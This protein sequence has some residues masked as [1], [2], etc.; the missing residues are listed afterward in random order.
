MVSAEHPDVTRPEQWTPE[1]AAHFLRSIMEWTT[2]Q[3][4]PAGGYFPFIGGVAHPV[5]RGK[6][7]TTNTRVGVISTLRVLFRDLRRWK[8]VGALQITLLKTYASPTL[9]R[10]W[11]VPIPAISARP[12]G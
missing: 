1:L 3:Y 4:L 8:L 5:R 11:S 12:Y 6:P 10:G 2:G 9:W 7:L